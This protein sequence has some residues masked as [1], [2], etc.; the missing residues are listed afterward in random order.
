MT[1]E[2]SQI[3]L[4]S[5][6]E[7]PQI[8]IPV[9]TSSDTEYNR[10]SWPEYAAAV[11]AAGAEALRIPL[12][13]GPA[14]WKRF[15]AQCS[16]FLLPGS[17]ADVDPARYGQS[18][19][20]ATAPADVRREGCDQELLDHAE[21]TGK[22]VMG[23]CFGMQSLNV[24]R[25][26]TLLQDVSPV[27]VNHG[28]G[29]SVAVAHSVQVASESLLGGLLTASEAPAEGAWRRLPV[30][31]SHHQAVEVA[32]DDLVITARCSQDG[33]A[34]ALEGR[35]GAAAVLGVQWHPERSVDRSAASRALFAWLVSEAADYAERLRDGSHASS[36]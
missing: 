10:R 18:R 25:G 1:T 4:R 17:P 24:W 15:A 26:G 11:Q 7:G 19:E 8:G 27:P 14:E 30:N 12:E 34:E 13:G 5:E 21:K 6:A 28:A 20:P 9:P 23:I 29:A 2:T 22:P 31:S 3:E 16:G 33:V 35:L 32:G 36:L